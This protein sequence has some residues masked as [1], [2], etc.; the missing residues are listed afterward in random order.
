MLNLN[1]KCITFLRHQHVTMK[2][3]DRHQFT[4]RISIIRSYLQ[5]KSFRFH[6]G[7]DGTIFYVYHALF[8]SSANAIRHN[9][10]VKNRAK[11]S[12]H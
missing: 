12:V 6:G 5:T 7:F 9:N 4:R 1:V 10:P 8:K 3:H 2:A 11:T